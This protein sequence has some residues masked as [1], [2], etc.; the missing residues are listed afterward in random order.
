MYNYEVKEVTAI[1]KALRWAILIR[2]V[3]LSSIL[4]PGMAIMYGPGS[5]FLSARL[6]YFF[7]MT[8]F[9][10]ILE[11]I[12]SRGERSIIFLVYSHMFFDL[13]VISSV[14]DATGAVGSSFTFL[15]I[16]LILEAGLF[17]ERSGALMW[18][19]IS[20]LVYLLLGIL[21]FWGEGPLFGEYEG[22][23]LFFSG[24]QFH[25]FFDVF[26]P[27]SLFY[28]VALA[29][30]FISRRLDI[31]GEQIISLDKELKR[32]SLESSD[33]LR[34]V[35]TGVMTCDLSGKLVFANPACLSIL[36]L[37]SEKAIGLQLRNLFNERHEKLGKL[38]EKTI[39][40]ETPISRTNVA[41]SNGKEAEKVHLGVSTSFLRDVD[42]VVT[43]VTTIFQ[44]ISHLKKMSVLKRSTLRL[45]ALTELSSLM[46]NEIRNPLATIRGSLEML[47]KNDSNDERRRILDIVRNESDKLLQLLEDF[48]R[49]AK[50]KVRKW[51]RVN[52]LEMLEEIRVIFEVRPDI[53]SRIII[54]H[55]GFEGEG[56]EVVYG[57]SGLLKQLFLILFVNAAEA[58]EG[59][60]NIRVRSEKS[61]HPDKGGR[62][63]SKNYR[64]I[65]VE[66]DGPGFSIETA[67][68]A[69]DPFYT[70]KNGGNGL[71]LAIAQRIVEA[72]RGTIELN[73]REGNGSCFSLLLPAINPDEM[74]IEKRIQALERGES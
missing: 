36:G 53:A 3:V 68:K 9:F 14:V 52:L 13:I 11:Y 74:R 41:V 24:S 28:L 25:P 12:Y 21:R 48:L 17:L 7:V 6:S 70:T 63:G 35:P 65:C 72:H 42:G 43:G 10:S 61:A 55:E 29:I 50:I 51:N 32:L 4:L 56:K 26:F 20:S 5:Q 19:T 54:H 47:E 37:K 59:Q 18:A 33:I 64:S 15:Y 66:D 57:D 71:G 38:I 22:N 40:E 73:S 67:A 30:G 49:F 62:S 44:D 23:A 31:E 1:T 34:H 39:Q 8:I 60:G 2:I 16:L 69:F 46:T 45:R 58:I 27:L